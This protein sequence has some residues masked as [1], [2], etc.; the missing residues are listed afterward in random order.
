MF[1]L[2]LSGIVKPR[3]PTRWFQL[4]H[5]NL[6]SCFEITSLIIDLLYTRD[7]STHCVTLMLSSKH[8]AAYDPPHMPLITQEPRISQSRK[9]LELMHG[10]GNLVSPARGGR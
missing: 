6:R 10:W 7:T 9:Y 3:V 2:T 8:S 5:H 1:A 4:Q